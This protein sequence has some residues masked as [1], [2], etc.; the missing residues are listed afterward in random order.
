MSYARKQFERYLTVDEEK[1]L[2]SYVA[3]FGDVMS[4]RDYAWMGVLRQSGMRV[5]AMSL[6]TVEDA[7][8]SLATGYFHI[9]AETNKGGKAYTVKANKKALKH[10]S[11]L[12]SIRV[13]MGFLEVNGGA[14]VMGRNHKALSIRSYQDRI[15]HWRF[16][17][18]LKCDVSPHWFR[19]TLAKRIISTSVSRNPLAIVQVVL[20]HASIVSTGVYTM[21]DKEEL[22]LSMEAAS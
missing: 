17:A 10:L 18:G 2:F 5:K 4:R 8:V 7:R 16:A 3:Q 9:R 19:H 1:K 15:K 20:G 22:S 11:A 14:L 12:L 6:F 21:P 13:E